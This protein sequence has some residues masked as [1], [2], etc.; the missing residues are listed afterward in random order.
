MP[1]RWLDRRPLARTPF[2][3]IKDWN[4]LHVALERTG[5]FGTCP[6]YKVRIVGDGSVE[7]EGREFV[8]LRGRHRARLARES[9]EKL[10]DQFRRADF[11]WL[12]DNYAAM[13]TDASSKTLEISY[14]GN[15]KRVRDYIGLQ[16]GMPD[17]VT[18][19]EY[20]VDDA[21]DTERW[22]RGNNNTARSLTEERWNFAS[23]TKENLT[24]VAG[25]TR[26]GEPSA[27]RDVIALGPPVTARVDAEP[28]YFEPDKKT[29]ALEVAVQRGDPRILSVLISAAHWARADL[30]EA[31]LLAALYGRM[32]IVTPLLNAG[33]SPRYATQP[34]A[35]PAKGDAFR[36]PGSGSRTVLMN[37]AA[38]GMPDVVETTLRAKPDVNARDEY[39]WTALHF[40]VWRGGPRYGDREAPNGAR[41][42]ELLVA[43]GADVNARTIA[44][45]TALMMSKSDDEMTKALIRAGAR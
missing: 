22:T 15:R 44:G 5:C 37:A 28:S 19:L 3:P 24:I 13:M 32:S 7:Y 21:A 41:V 34:A 18:N 40:A 31:L 16:V 6:D 38:S 30:N 26:Y 12:H 1:I 11:F 4:S 25:I 27:L 10:F 45:A 39:G 29:T 36:G 35:L 17:A 2:P 20:A 33:A 43:A 23:R 14:D 9:I 8:A 42:V